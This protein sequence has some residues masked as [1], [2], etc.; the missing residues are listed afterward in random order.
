MA[1]VFWANVRIMKLVSQPFLYHKFHDRPRMTMWISTTLAIFELVCAPGVWFIVNVCAFN[2][3]P[4]DL[5]RLHSTTRE[6]HRIRS[7]RCVSPFFSLKYLTGIFRLSTCVKCL[8]YDRY[9]PFSSC[10]SNGFGIKAQQPHTI[11]QKITK[12]KTIMRDSRLKAR[13]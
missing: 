12:I 4:F 3:N 7:F 10:V 8:T 11:R 6:T 5:I 13:I 2:Y 1:Y 9:S